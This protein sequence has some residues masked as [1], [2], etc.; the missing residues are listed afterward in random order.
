MRERSSPVHLIGDVLVMSGLRST[1]P[2]CYPSPIPL[3]IDSMPR[4]SVQ[5]VLP[6]VIVLPIT[7][8][9]LVCNTARVG[10]RL[11][12]PLGLTCT[13]LVIVLASGSHWYSS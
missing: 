7:P 8:L 10:T 4:E 9:L 5:S 12:I 2:D 6:A 1:T 13:G 3:P 11:V